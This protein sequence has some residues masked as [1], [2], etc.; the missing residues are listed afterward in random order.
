MKEFRR[1]KRALSPVIATVI[2]VSVTIVVAV[3]VAYWLGTIAATYTSYEQ[4]DLPKTWA[5][6]VSK[7]SGEAVD[8]ASPTLNHYPISPDSETIH[9]TGESVGTATDLGDESF[10]VTNPPVVADSQTIKVDGIAWTEVAVLDPGNG[11][12]EYLFDDATGMITFGIVDGDDD[13]ALGAVITADYDTTDYTIDYASGTITFTTAP[14]AGVVITADYVPVGLPGW[15]VHIGLKNSGSAD[16][17]IDDVFLNDKPLLY[18][19]AGV[20]LF[21]GTD[22]PANKVTD[23]SKITVP[24]SKGSATE[25][26]LWIQEKDTAGNDVVEGCTH[27]TMINL[28]IHS[29]GGL[30]YPSQVRLP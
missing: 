23:L 19:T 27:G 7:V 29:S 17:T 9:L 3:S 18:Y 21:V 14:K 2:L 11:V 8:L 24:L 20:N 4:V 12:S 15:K 30:D 10:P 25:L 26:I 28:K 5:E 22:D 16:T 6:F 13:P 1:N